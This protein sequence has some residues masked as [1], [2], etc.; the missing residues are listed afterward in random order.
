MQTLCVFCGS[1]TGNDPLYIEKA[2]ELGHKMADAGL[3]LVY[4]G[5]SIG[6]MGELADA[7]IERRGRV[8]GVIPKFLY[9]KELGHEGVTE[10][11]VV[12]SMHERK[13]K[14]A[15][16]A[17][18][19]LAMPGGIGTMEELF[20]VFT[21]SQLSL[22]RKPVALFNLNHYFD[23]L[24]AFLDHMVTEGFLVEEMRKRLIT[25]IDAEI[26]LKSMLMYS[27]N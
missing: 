16:R 6:L 22:I 11:I 3:E 5:G 8:T 24:L 26:V 18:G 1:S 23:A 25:G 7:V 4:G 13:M 20:E 9:D 17:D 19:F 14:M 15:E 12:D 21:W 27:S 10:L 2:R